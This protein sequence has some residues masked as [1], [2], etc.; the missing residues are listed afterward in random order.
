MR[1]GFARRSRAGSVAAAMAAVV[2][3]SGVSSASAG[4]LW[5]GTISP[6]GQIAVRT[7]G[8]KPTF[9]DGTPVGSFSIR[10]VTDGLLPISNGFLLIRRTAAGV[11]TCYTE[12]TPVVRVAE[13]LY[14]DLDALTHVVL[15]CQNPNY[16][17]CTSCRVERNLEGYYCACINNGNNVGECLSRM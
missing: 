12:A 5:V 2:C 17:D 6:T 14:L 16:P 3:L 11:G 1:T 10:E 13:R 4:Q 15:K 9:P 7:Q 8:L